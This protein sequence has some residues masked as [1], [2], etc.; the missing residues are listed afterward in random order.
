MITDDTGYVESSNKRVC[1][2][3][4]STAS[5]SINTENEMETLNNT[6]DE[7]AMYDDVGQCVG[8]KLTRQQISYL[9]RHHIVPPEN[10]K[11]PF[12][13]HTK[14]GKEG[15]R[16]LKR[17]HLIAFKPWLVYS[18][19]KKGLFCL[20]CYLF[21]PKDVGYNSDREVMTL[22]IKPLTKFAN[23]LGKGG[24]LMNHSSNKY[25]LKAI[26]DM[27]NF[28]KTYDKPEMAIAN[29]VDES[30][31][32]QSLE[33]RNRLKPIVQTLIL[34]AKQNIPLRG[35]R[36]D[37]ALD[38]DTSNVKT[39]DG[40]F[41]NLL[42]YRIQGGDVILKKHLESANSNATYISKT[43][44]NELIECCGEVVTDFILEEIKTA[45]FYAVIFDETTDIAKKSQMTMVLR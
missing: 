24:R 8:F 29:I 20:A 40:N 6:Y 17:E 14:Y 1:I 22:V 15:K 19:F 32:N 28:L 4:A 35:H 30:S 31:K 12:S 39:N 44:Q 18:I 23:L 34:C 25:H 38:F 43:T 16:Y 41:R 7:D 10:F 13:V 36:D 3:A 45:K 5:T 27:D 9:L 37:G 26:Q 11:Y 33:N 21:A 2:V 42:R